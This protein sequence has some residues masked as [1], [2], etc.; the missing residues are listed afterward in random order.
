MIE[1]LIASSNQFNSIKRLIESKISQP[2]VAEWFSGKYKLYNE[3]SILVSDGKETTR[4]P[5][6]VMITDDK[7][8]VVDYKFGKENNEYNKQVKRYMDLL[9]DMGYKNVKGYLWYVYKNKIEEVK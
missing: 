4:R 6:R 8:I 5:D 7:A 1:G 2:Q 3:C 9:A